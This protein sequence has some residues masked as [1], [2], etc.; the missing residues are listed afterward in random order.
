MIVASAILALLLNRQVPASTQDLKSFQIGPERV[1]LRFPEPSK[2]AAVSP[3]IA[4][5]TGW[6]S[7]A[8]P[9][10]AFDLPFLGTGSW[11]GVEKGFLAASGA[12]SS[13][14]RIKIV[15]LVSADALFTRDDGLIEDRRTSIIGGRLQEALDAVPQ[16]IALVSA[17]TE[18]KL[19]IVPDVMIDVE[20]IRDAASA[21]KP[22]FDHAYLTHYLGSRI[23]GGLYDAEDKLYR[24]PFNSVLF[25]DPCAR[26]SPQL[27]DPGVRKSPPLFRVDDTPASEVSFDA[28]VAGAAPGNLA[29]SIFDA[30]LTTVTDRAIS[31]GLPTPIAPLSSTDWAA[32]SSRDEVP[33]DTLLT[34]LASHP[35]RQTGPTPI[36]SELLQHT[37]K[38]ANIKLSILKDSAKGDVLEYDEARTS[39][40]G[41]FCLPH[42][43][44]PAD[45]GKT[46][47]FSLSYRT[48][49][50]RPV[51]L[52]FHDVKGKVHWVSLGRDPKPMDAAMPV[53]HSLP[54]QPDGAWHAVSV[55][56]HAFGPELIDQIRIGASPSAQLLSTESPTPVSYE[57]ADFRLGSDA[58]TPA[59]SAPS[60][61]LA[62]SDPDSRSLAALEAGK[63]DQPSPDLVQLLKDSDDR[64]VL[65]ALHAYNTVKDPFVEPKLIELSLSPVPRIAEFALRA[66]DHLDTPN[67]RSTIQRSLRS[68]FEY[69]REISAGLIGAKRDP[70]SAEDLVVLLA[71]KSWHTRLASVD[72]LALIPSKTAGIMRL[73]MLQQDDPI[74]KLAVIRNTD[75]AD[76]NA[77][78]K[79]QWTAVNEPSDEVRAASD[80][81]LIQS[82]VPGMQAE[83]LKG[84]RDDSSWT[85]ILV[86]H[87]LQEHPIEP[88]RGAIKLAL[89]DRSARVRAAAIDALSSLK[90]V[91]LDDI[92]N[93]LADA[94]PTVDLALV[95]LSKKTGLTLPTATLTI[96]KQSPDP[97]VVSAIQA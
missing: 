94:N 66:L 93:C 74:I 6:T 67:A 5:W 29:I 53:A 73:A 85:R 44:S 34:R 86:L 80:I 96:L 42:G 91:T 48:T 70:A 2:D 51:A 12:S 71:G 77:M 39:R 82:T 81:Q 68:G 88:A 43:P 1:T 49:S 75:P 65:N 79:L 41:G 23:N 83:G 36:P 28:S 89:S 4:N 25:I 78:R 20:P 21:S 32:I 87:Y 58:A 55:D 59:L 7:L 11:S 26:Y 38:T 9:K 92:Q 30:W 90:S 56:L 14:W 15:L 69:S 19:K 61:D 95:R 22:G 64:V 76:E 50:D 45:P 62:S 72:S 37:Y 33:T 54:T 97:A 52:A 8:G 16:F 18:G 24:G 57:F 3:D 27:E 31:K 60:A 13:E 63:K 84:V 10:P 47:T 35:S 46:P 17:A 40:S